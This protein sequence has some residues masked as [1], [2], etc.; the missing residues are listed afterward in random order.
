[1]AAAHIMNKEVEMAMTKGAGDAR[2]AGHP[3]AVGLP[4]P[5]V[6]AVQLTAPQVGAGR[7]L[8]PAAAIPVL[9]GTATQDSNA[10]TQNSNAIAADNSPAAAAVPVTAAGPILVTVTAI[11]APT[12]AATAIAAAAATAA[13]ANYL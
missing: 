10:A 11:A 6:V 3:A 12:A 7:V 8:L 4:L 9:P 2:A 13:T 1:M 5:P